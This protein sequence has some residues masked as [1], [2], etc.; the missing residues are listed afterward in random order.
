[1]DTS[2]MKKSKL[3]LQNAWLSAFPHSPVSQKTSSPCPGLSQFCLPKTGEEAL[4]HLHCNE[5]FNMWNYSA[6]LQWAHSYGKSPFGRPS[7]LMAD[8]CKNVKIKYPVRH[9]HTLIIPHVGDNFLYQVSIKAKR[10]EENNNNNIGSDIRKKK[11]IR[12]CGW[13][14]EYE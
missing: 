3:P 4:G 8:T 11:F 6:T 2:T 12:L 5:L 1:M 7:S 9:G 14:K 13:Q 10:L